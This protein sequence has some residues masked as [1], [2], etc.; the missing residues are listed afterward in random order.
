[1]IGREVPRTRELKEGLVA[2]IQ[3]IDQVGLLVD[4]HCCILVA[5][6]G[7]WNKSSSVLVYGLRLNIEVGSNHC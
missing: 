2:K 1:M 4:V 3:V 7:Q 6:V 5:C